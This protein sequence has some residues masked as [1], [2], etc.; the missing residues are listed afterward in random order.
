MFIVDTILARL[1]IQDM[2]IEVE[3]VLTA[4]RSRGGSISARLTINNNEDILE[5]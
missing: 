3:P 4:S 5:K 2:L 1:T